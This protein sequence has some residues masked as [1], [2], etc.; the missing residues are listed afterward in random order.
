[1]QKKNTPDARNRILQAALHVF[2]QKSFEGSRIEEIAKEAGVPKSLIYYHFKSKEDMYHVLTKQFIE[3]YKELVRPGSG[4]T[5]QT[6]AA[7][8]SEKSELHKD[9]VIR[10]ADMIRIIFL[11]SLKKS[12][13]KPMIF[14]VVEAL[15]ETEESSEKLGD[16]EGY[17][18]Q[19]RLVAEFFTNIIPIY[20]YLCFSEA[21][22]QHFQ[23]PR[24]ALDEMFAKV[25][26]ETHGAYHKN[27]T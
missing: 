14:E 20:A 22:T 6:K 1:M 2:A 25:F 9:F 3:A 19:E 27:H 21:W 13:E 8:I 16:E 7:H 18:R 11:D 23:V 15:V 10:H 17:D 4:E 5:H 24:K 26:E 12:S